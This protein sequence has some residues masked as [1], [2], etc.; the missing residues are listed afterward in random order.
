MAH[1]QRRQIQVDVRKNRAQV[2]QSLGRRSTIDI[3]N[4]RFADFD[5]R[6]AA[7]WVPSRKLKQKLRIGTPSLD[8]QFG[9]S[10]RRGRKPIRRNVEQRDG[11][12]LT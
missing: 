5:A 9:I 6:H 10:D 12:G 8:L 4:V 11:N 2:R 3:F 7:Q 1:K